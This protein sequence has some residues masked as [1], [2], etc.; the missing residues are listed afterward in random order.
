MRV[1]GVVFLI[2]AVAG[3]A[4]ASRLV[5]TYPGSGQ[6]MDQHQRD[7]AECDAW[8]ARESQAEP[9]AG[10]VGGAVVGGVIGAAAGTLLGLVVG[11]FT[12]DLGGGA[13]MGAAL[14][15]AMG[16]MQGAAGGAASEHGRNLDAYRACM[17]GKGYAVR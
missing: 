1:A 3:C 7:K 6:S 17:M 16:G 5:M 10:A 15:G 13:A 11:A 2:L 8:A 14:G 4:P 12:H 9:G